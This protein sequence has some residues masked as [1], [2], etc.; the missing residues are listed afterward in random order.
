V[1]KDRLSGTGREEPPIRRGVPE[2]QRWMSFQPALQTVPSILVDVEEH[3][4]VPSAPVPLRLLARWPSALAALW[5][6]LGPA[7]RTDAWKA[8][9]ARLRRVVLAGM[10]TLPHPVELQWSALVARGF[11]EDQR[12]E[13]TAILSEHNAAMPAQTLVSAFSWL[14]FGAPEIGVEG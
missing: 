12:L 5:D 13:L 2:W 7:A 1:R 14:A 4:A 8:G 9:V 3:M 10:A 6:E 11:S